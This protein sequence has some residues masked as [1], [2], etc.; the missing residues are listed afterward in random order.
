MPNLE[1]T[2]YISKKMFVKKMIN[3]DDPLL[4]SKFYSY[5]SS[6]I[7]KPFVE[8]FLDALNECRKF[9]KAIIPTFI[10]Y[11]D[12]D[13]CIDSHAILLVNHNGIIFLYDPNGVITDKGRFR[14]YLNGK[15]YISVNIEKKYNIIMPQKIGI[16]YYA[17]CL[18]SNKTKYIS[19]GGYCMFYVWIAIDYIVKRY[20]KNNNINLIKLCKQLANPVFYNG[21]ST[22]F[23]KRISILSRKIVDL[24]LG[25]PRDMQAG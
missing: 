20:N 13:D 8:K 17:P 3:D 7:V 2:A 14:Y 25:H 10:S 5:H 21:L 15:S 1:F 9:S 22:C 23:P 24:S 12:D 11:I 18:A 6:E 19:F 4:C 16:Q